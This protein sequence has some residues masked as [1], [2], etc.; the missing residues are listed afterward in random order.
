MLWQSNIPVVPEVHREANAHPICLEDRQRETA[1][2]AAHLLEVQGGTHMLKPLINIV[3]G[4]HRQLAA[5]IELFGH[6]LV[7]AL[8]PRQLGLREACRIEVLAT[9][10]GVWGDLAPLPKPRCIR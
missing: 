9:V 10:L 5:I 7:L 2:S 8:D 6:V 4:D 3:G 1:A